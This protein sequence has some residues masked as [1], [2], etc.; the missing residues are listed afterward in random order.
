MFVVLADSRTGSHLLKSLLDSHPGLTC[1]DEIL[2]RRKTDKDFYTLGQGEGCLVSYPNLVE[3]NRLADGNDVKRLVQLIGECP[4]IH[5]TRDVNERAKSQLFYTRVQVRK[6]VFRKGNLECDIVFDPELDQ[7]DDEEV[8][9]LK[10]HFIDR[11]RECL[12]Q[13]T[14]VRQHWLEIDYQ[15]L[16][17]N[18]QLSSLSLEKSTVLCNYLKVPVTELCTNLYKIRR[19]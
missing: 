17:E 19:F 10:A 4:V 8:E 3:G 16:C 2:G 12:Q 11:Q 1:Y 7:Y 18:K 9:V 15:W 14:Q 5:L 6:Q 13:F